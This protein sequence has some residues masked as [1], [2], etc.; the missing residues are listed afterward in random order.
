MSRSA[1]FA[2]KLVIT[3]KLVIDTAKTQIFNTET[4]KAP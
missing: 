1:D 4:I 3:A 2:V